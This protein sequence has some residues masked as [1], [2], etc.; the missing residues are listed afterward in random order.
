MA[1]QT[2]HQVMLSEDVWKWPEFIA[3]AKRLGIDN[4]LPMTRLVIELELD[5]AAKVGIE[6]WATD[7]NP[8]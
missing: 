6:F 2:I 1:K 7:S 3:L 8:R 4:S 5:C